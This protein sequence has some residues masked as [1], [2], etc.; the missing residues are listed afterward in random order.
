MNRVF[1]LILIVL[2]TAACAVPLPVAAQDDTFIIAPGNLLDVTVYQDKELS[3][4]YAVDAD[5]TIDMPLAR[6]VKVGGLSIPQATAKIEG[7]LA[8]YIKEPQVS[9][10]TE[11]YGNIYVMG[12]VTRPG[13][14]RLSGDMHVLEAVGMA[15]GMKPTA[16]PNRVKVI[17]READ[18]SSK[19]IKVELKKIMGSGDLSKDVALKPGDVIVVP[20]RIF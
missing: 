1:R 5:G 20:E 6:K 4:K 16:A 12:E 13:P 9:I 14:I 19:A 10:L 11:N 8:K 15:G 7:A 17:R 18:G 2:I 3:K